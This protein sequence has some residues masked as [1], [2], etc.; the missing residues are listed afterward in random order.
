M[1]KR[2]N[3]ILLYTLPVANKTH[4]DKTVLTTS[5]S[6]PMSRNL[7]VIATFQIDL[8]RAYLTFSRQTALPSR[9]PLVQVLIDLSI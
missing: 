1:T 4:D 5:R 7:R 6:L 9:N 2:H 3:T 8:H